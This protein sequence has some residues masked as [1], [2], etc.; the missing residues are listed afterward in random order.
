MSQ[1]AI[2]FETYE[3][4]DSPD[5]ARMDVAAFI[6][7]VSPRAGATLPGPVVQRLRDV[8]GDKIPT[9]LNRPVSVS[10]LAMFE[11]LY[12][13]DG[14]LASVA[15]I[16]GGTLAETLPGSGVDAELTI[17][18]DGVLHD[19][20]LLPL[21]LS[22]DEA[23]T[24]IKRAINLAGLPV[25]AQLVATGNADALRFRLREDHG[26][27]TLAV[28]PYPTLGFPQTRRAEAEI[29]PSP[30]AMAVRQF[31]AGGGTTAVIV[32][33]GRPTA[34]SI[35]RSERLAYLHRLLLREPLKDAS[36][37][38]DLRDALA[39]ANPIAPLEP[40][41][42]HGIEH[43]LATEDVTFLCLP[44]LPE[45]VAPR[46]EKL[47]D[48][49]ILPR[50]REAFTECLPGDSDAG[51][52][53]SA[54]LRAPE[55]D[56][57]GRIVWQDALGHVV[58]R[59]SAEM[60]DK[61][62]L[63]ALPRNLPGAATPILPDSAFLQ[64]AEGWVRSRVSLDAP[65]GLLAP[66]APLAAQLALSARRQGTYL[67]AANR[68]VASLRDVEPRAVSGLSTCRFYSDIRGILLNKDLTTSSD[69]SWADAPV[70]RLTALLLR[71]C[72]AL[73][74]R[75]TFEPS[76][77]NLWA[78]TRTALRGLLRT[79]YRSGALAG[80]GEGTSFDVVCDHSTMTQ[81]DIDEGR[82]IAELSF[83]PA[84]PVARI[85]VRLPITQGGT[86]T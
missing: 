52:E 78:N 2:S 26:A 70:S 1:P 69:P 42:W 55:L 16:T 59:V 36:T 79:V 33:M 30:V 54:R 21:P 48:L 39:R 14:R 9:I 76:G 82:L 18:V 23:L 20:K 24:R 71:E 67:S 66:D 37:S 25:D 6:G 49:P 85:T 57:I 13:P 22:P 40:G 10:S 3:V 17:I 4:A 72:R 7:F 15:E 83:L 29:L 41:D 60:R 68:P 77:P 81:Q 31:F 62:V 5:P 46:P 51:S 34:Y 43:L 27:G 75:L 19:L 32:A 38:E 74:N 44:D 11:A 58:A 47:A 73:G 45:L 84:R 61:I 80:R 53:Q 63:A 65:E 35:N 56:S 64:V 28:L 86:R 12:E 50:P 8:Y